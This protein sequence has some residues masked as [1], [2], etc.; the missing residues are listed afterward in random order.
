MDLIALKMRHQELK[1]IV[2]KG[3]QN[4]LPDERVRL[5]KK[6]RLRIKQLLEK[7]YESL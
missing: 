5:F 7:Q 6:E 4:Y 1:S 3:Y 2:Q